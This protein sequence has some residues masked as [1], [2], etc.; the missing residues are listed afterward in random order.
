MHEV[1][2]LERWKREFS[3]EAHRA[4]WRERVKEWVKN[5]PKYYSSQQKIDEAMARAGSPTFGAIIGPS[6]IA[7][8]EQWREV[9]R[10]DERARR[11]A[12]C[13]V[14]V[15]ALGE[16]PD[17]RMTKIGGAPFWPVGC[18][19]PLDERGRPLQFVG[20][21]CFVDSLDLGLPRLPGDILSVF[22]ALDEE[23]ILLW[24]YPES[25]HFK[26]LRADA[27]NAADA[28]KFPTFDRPLRAVFGVRHRTRD[29]DLIQ[30]DGD[31]APEDQETYMI[32]TLEATKI[33]GF[34]YWIQNEVEMDGTY[35]G[36]MASIQVAYQNIWPFVNVQR[37]ESPSEVD[38]GLLRF[39]DMGMV[40]LFLNDDGSVGVSGDC[41]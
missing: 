9:L 21:L 36:S 34:P 16:P 37:V 3:L 29:L 6:D 20:Q 24:P 18:E 19:W 23:G 25:Y 1:L 27:P 26:W 28:T 13:D 10:M 2:D 5:D 14:F 35:L 17:S 31:Y 7:I 33:G 4:Y 11:A 30:P 41:Y 22:I 32:S 12:P 40:N 39:A 15:W 8:V 38:E